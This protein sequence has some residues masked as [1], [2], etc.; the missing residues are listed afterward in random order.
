MAESKN[1]TI[2][3]ER[4]IK[5]IIKLLRINWY[6]FLIF[7]MIGAI[8][9][10]FIIHKSTTVYLV[11]TTLLLKNSEDYNLKDAILQGLGATP[12]YDDV[13]NDIRIIKST[14]IIEKTLSKLNFNISY[15]IEGRIKT[16]E[17]YRGT[18]FSVTAAIYNPAF[19]SV[20]FF[21]QI[22]D[23]NTF[24]LSYELE[25]EKYNRQHRFGEKINSSDYSLLI[26]K[27]QEELFSS[28]VREI[29]YY[30]IVNDAGALVGKYASSL[31]VKQYD[32]PAA[33]IDINVTDDIAERGRD[34][35]DS[36]SNV[37]LESSIDKSNQV[38]NKTLTFIDDLLKEVV[39]KLNN[40][41]G[42]L[43]EFKKQNLTLELSSEQY[44]YFS[45]ILNL[46]QEKAQLEI[47]AKSLSFWYDYVIQNK[48]VTNIPPNLFQGSD[49]SALYSEYADLNKERTLLEQN[50]SVDNFKLKEKNQQ[51]D[52]IR[53]N[54]TNFLSLSR[55][56]SQEKINLL[57]VQIKEYE[58]YFRGLPKTER[59]LVNIQ[60]QL[61]VNEKIYIFLLEKKAEN[62]ISKAGIIP[63]K[64]V[65]E[66]ARSRG[67]VSPDKKKT[68]MTYVGI[69]IALA[70]LIVVIRKMFFETIDSKEDLKQY[71]T[72]PIFGIIGKSKEAKENY[73]VIEAKPKS[74]IT[75]A[76]RALRA[77][78]EYL[79]P[80]LD[81][82]VILITSC[83]ANEGKTFCAT[84]LAAIIA[85]ADKKVLLIGLDLHKPKLH[86]ALKLPNDIGITSVL[87]GKTTLDKAIKNTA[88]DTLDVLLTG[89]TP[90]N[91]SELVFSQRL[92]AMINEL[93]EKYDFII[94]DTP[95][96][97]ILSDA[98]ILMKVSDIN[99]FVIRA[100]TAR[101]QFIDLA[102]QVKETNNPKNLGFVLNGAS[103]RTT[104]GY[105]Y[106]YG[107]G[108]G[109]YGYGYYS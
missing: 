23:K 33:Y 82:K 65:L 48:D 74:P 80:G 5:G 50:A 75:E 59:E 89:A 106:G 29:N 57:S 51:L 4:D 27:A 13:E 2:I 41:E 81:K 88:I 91:A 45:R 73:L 9:A 20:K 36:L 47:Q 43:E 10:N 28:E 52:R 56:S 7:I 63:E 102:H 21:V 8:V 6:V 72:L 87:I 77:N 109:N 37:Y 49:V 79:A 60:R 18:P 58:E 24:K 30:F 1:T 66:P 31:S 84:N 25:N 14:P 105:A 101:K 42:N 39:D 32:Y 40:I 22:I 17:V 108:Y 70:L 16:T 38:N 62:I 54:I 98:L 95:P 26:E 94:I 96:I 61:G 35:L 97:G 46:E 107:Y 11:S 44:S 34:F 90:P 69:G 92:N 104:Y 99:L 103:G 19:H 64:S 85:K 68:N 76:F 86:E 100:G 67:I 3:D 71:S 83:M 12:Q 78:F 53:T 93:K 55:K 15:F